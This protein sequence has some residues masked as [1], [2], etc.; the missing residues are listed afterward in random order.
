MFKK[1]KIFLSRASKKQLCKLY[2]AALPL[3]TVQPL[4]AHSI[5]SCNSFYSLYGRFIKSAVRGGFRVKN[6]NRKYLHSSGIISP[7]WTILA[8]FSRLLSNFALPFAAC[9]QTHAKYLHMYIKLLLYIYFFTS[10]LTHSPP[11]RV[12]LLFCVCE[13]GWLRYSSSALLCRLL[14]TTSTFYS[15]YS[16]VRMFTWSSPLSLSLSLFMASVVAWNGQ[17]QHLCVYASV[18]LH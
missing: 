3:T 18:L 10:E 14:S 8:R 2:K 11:F 4:P 12:L 15:F 13:A 7:R 6:S 16:S 5:I 17:K 1:F 9:M